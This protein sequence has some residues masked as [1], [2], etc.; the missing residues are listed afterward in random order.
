EDSALA[1][2]PIVLLSVAGFGGANPRGTATRAWRDAI[3]RLRAARVVQCRD[4]DARLRLG[5][6]VVGAWKPPAAWVDGG[7]LVVSDS[8]AERFDRLAEVGQAALARADL[9]KDLRLVL[10]SLNGIARPSLADVDR[11][12]TRCEIDAVRVAEVRQ[13]WQGRTSFLVDRLRPV[14]AL[15][16]VDA[17]G[18]DVAAAD[19]DA[20]ER[21]LDAHV[22]AWPAP[23]LLGAARRART[24]RD[25]GREAFTVLGE[26]AELHRWNA[27]LAGLGE[28]YAPVSNDRLT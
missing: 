26:R 4:I 6:E 22:E 2:L 13:L 20:L 27:V 25:M 9:V 21:W 24:D 16:S 12:L 1:W 14:L 17:A 8:A 23:E 7:V 18:L 5:D 3:D 28:R 15:L 11:A 10:G 19:L